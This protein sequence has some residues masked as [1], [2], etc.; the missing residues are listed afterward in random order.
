M[1]SDQPKKILVIEDDEDIRTVVVA[2]LT[3]AGYET[4]VAFDGKDGLRRFYGDR[5]DL[6]VLDIAMPVMDGWQVLERLREVSE[7][8][9]LILTAATQER[10]KLRG[11][12]SGADDY[13]TK[14][15]SGEELLARIE[16]ALRRASSS[17]E[18][19]ETTGYSDLEIAIDFQKHEVFVRGEPIALSPTEFRLL[20]A[21]TRSANQV[22]SQDQL[23]D[24]VWGSEYVGSL[25]VVRLYVGY[26]RRKIERNHE[27][28]A[29][30][31][32][33]RGFGYRY[34]R[35]TA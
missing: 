6:V 15:F 2:R 33:V 27:V 3:R 14:P 28:P 24:Q 11:L 35:P 12:R 10:D 18:E 1:A 34:R 17:A 16:V 30:I 32:T 26:L 19:A 9:V 25:E 29:L 13:I 21:L 31:E 23:L 5:P 8:P 20:A 7:V 4:T 22:L